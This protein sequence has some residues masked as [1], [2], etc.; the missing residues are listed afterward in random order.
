MKFSVASTN[1]TKNNEVNTC[2]AITILIS[3]LVSRFSSPG[4]GIMS[5]KPSVLPMTIAKYK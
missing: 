4:L 5:P 3:L 1:L 2:N